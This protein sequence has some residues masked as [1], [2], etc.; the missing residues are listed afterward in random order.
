M[1]RPFWAKSEFIGRTDQRRTNRQTEDGW[2]NGERRDEQGADIRT[3]G[4]RT[5]D[6]TEDRWSNGGRTDKRRTYRQVEDKRTNGGRMN[7]GYMDK[8]RMDGRTNG[9]RTD[10]GFNIYCEP[11]LRLRWQKGWIA[12]PAT[13][14]NYKSIKPLFNHLKPSTV[15]KFLL[16]Y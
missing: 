7:K 12:P 2:L 4:G 1:K 8:R 9:G 15:I 3:N 5:D 6:Q 16:V 10:S 13:K 11:W 14:Q